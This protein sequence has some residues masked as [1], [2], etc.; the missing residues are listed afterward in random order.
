MVGHSLDLRGGGV[1]TV[2][3]ASNGKAALKDQGKGK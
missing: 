1:A 3:V 2:M